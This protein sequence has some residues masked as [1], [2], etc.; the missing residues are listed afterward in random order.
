MKLLWHNY[1]VSRLDNCAMKLCT[2]TGLRVYLTI[3]T[4]SPTTLTRSRVKR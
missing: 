3:D 1:L 4:T 2:Q